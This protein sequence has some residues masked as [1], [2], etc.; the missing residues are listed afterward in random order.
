MRKI[1][2][3]VVFAMLLL[4]V[5]NG[6]WARRVPL[7]KAERYA[8]N[9]WL[10]KD[11]NRNAVLSHVETEFGNIYLFVDTGGRGFVMLAA[12]DRS[13]PV[14]GYS[15]RNN[16]V[17]D[18]MPV[19]VHDWV[20]DYDD[21]IQWLID[22]NI[23][24]TNEIN[25]QWKD[26][27]NERRQLPAAYPT[28]KGPLVQTKWNQSS[29]YN[30]QCPYD[31]STR[32][33][34][35]CVATATAQIMKYHGWPTIGM[36]SHSYTWNSKSQSADFG[37][38]TYQWSNM[39][40]TYSSSSSSK[41]KDAVATL[42][43]HIGVAVEMDY[44]ANS[45]GA[46][47]VATNFDKAASVN[48]LRK[49]FKYKQTA[50]SVYR[51]N[52][53]DKGWKD[54]LKNEIDNSRPIQYSGFGSG[55][56]SFV[57]DGYDIDEK[58]HFNW[59]WGGSYDG[60]FAIGALNPGG[61]G[62]GASSTHTYNVNNA[63]IIGIEPDSST[64]TSITVTAS[65]NNTTYGTVTGGGTFNRYAEVTITPSAITGYRFV[66]WSTGGMEVPLKFLASGNNMS[67]T[68]NF[69]SIAGDT[70][71]YCKDAHASS[72]RLTST[73]TNYW[74]IRI[75]KTSLVSGKL[76]TH[77]MLYPSETGSY[78]LTV[79]SGDFAKSLPSQTFNITETDKWV[80]LELNTYLQI[81]ETK[82]LCVTFSHSGGYPC[83]VSASAANKDA[84]YGR[85][86]STSTWSQY[87]S[88]GANL[89][90]MIKAITAPT[91]QITMDA[92]S[93]NLT[94][95]TKDFDLRNVDL[96]VSNKGATVSYEVVSSTP[97]GIA[98][99]TDGC[100]IT[101]TGA[102]TVKIKASA[103]DPKFG[104]A[105]N[106][107]DLQISKGSLVFDNHNNTG[108]WDDVQNWYPHYDR[109]PDATNF[110]VDVNVL[111][112]IP[113]DKRAEC[114][115]LRIN[116][117]GSITVASTAVLNVKGELTNNDPSKLLIKADENGSGTVVF[118][119]GSPKATVEMYMKGTAESDGDGGII[120]PEWQLRGCIVSDFTLADPQDWANIHVYRWSESNNA[121]GCWT[122]NM[123]GSAIK[124]DP[125]WGYGFANYSTD[126]VPL[127]YT[128]T[129]KNGNYRL[130]LSKTGNGNANV[131]NNMFTNSYAA[132]L[133]IARLDF[134]NAK[135]SVI[136]YNT[137]SWLDWQRYGGDTTSANVGTTAGQ[138]LVC[139]KNTSAI[140][141]LPT[142]IPSGQSFYVVAEE[143]NASVTTYYSDIDDSNS[144]G[145]MFLPK[146]K[147]NEERFNVLGITITGKKGG[148][149]VVLIENENCDDS[150]NDGYDG[151]KYSGD[152]ELPQ[153]FAVN[154]F[155]N[156]SINAAKSMLGQK[157]G[158]TTQTAG[159]VLRMTFETDKLNDFAQLQ[160][161]DHAAN[162]Y[163]NV[164]A[165]E[166][167][168]FVSTDNDK[169][170]FEIVGFR[171]RNEMQDEIA[172][173]WVC[174]DHLFVGDYD[175]RMMMCDMSGKIVWQADVHK[176]EWVNLP[177]YLHGVYVIKTSGSTI[178]IAK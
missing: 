115:S 124:L 59:G 35:G 37:N 24:K 63:A 15:L 28:S 26:L 46:Y 16:F 162:R 165:G 167:Y 49:Y 33:V 140:A 134:E 31:G 93:V 157:I 53:S 9:W 51:E 169:S 144:S 95:A 54:I 106:T 23:E 88:G 68:A 3:I 160:V 153:L 79:Y 69:E 154:E 128:G 21:Q 139:P 125:W 175:G 75:P 62:A 118:K 173:I 14:L 119:S 159:E 87:A 44:G 10:Q 89:T 149:R 98:T 147:E 97:A 60:N 58:F 100:K 6:V 102:G 110:D 138:M 34:T 142:T 66:S 17:A 150:Y 2:K 151:M 84:S 174:N 170:R 171:M 47:D 72:Y 137:G 67:I 57:C 158:V 164:L 61:G 32:S 136:F 94:S 99:I 156:T 86:S 145:P 176:N 172:G 108:R 114:N 146:D 78:T 132:P 96:G 112:T 22:N 20:K 101:A 177:E 129:L 80:T 4:S 161:L 120:N 55:G 41:A 36:G 127:K 30:N 121:H 42:M 8:H 130:V 168:E 71:Y 45:S 81:D 85:T 13:L 116:A 29:P 39:T 113:A 50:T 107:I 70:L 135:S 105:E 73:G 131:G 5:N 25:A 104:P 141:G 1:I 56:H 65:S 178:K 83:T 133:R 91:H 152:A 103:T 122:E 19:H 76:L 163:I 126:P 148:D 52:Y 38:T 123:V 7:E 117:N 18:S 74:G 155:G 92:D 43:Y 77:V 12:D 111:C 143:N 109:L 27:E 64:A 166:E 90:W 48:A 40:N 82:D 11:G